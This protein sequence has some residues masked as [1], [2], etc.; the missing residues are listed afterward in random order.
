MLVMTFGDWINEALEKLKAAQVDSPRSDVFAMVEKVTGHEKAWT[1]AHSDELLSKNFIEELNSF[2]KRRAH[3]EPL[4]YILERAW[5]YGRTFRVT[6]DVLIPR[7]ESEDFI[8]ILKDIK[9]RSLVD[10]G[11]GSGCL[12]ISAKLEMPSCQ[13]TATDISEAA[14]KI[15]KQNADNYKVGINFLY[16]S[17]LRPLQ[18]TKYEALVANLPYVPEGLITS[19]EIKTEPSQGLFAGKD[20]LE[21]YRAFWNEIKNLEQ[22]PK[23][24]LT[25]AL[26]DQHSQLKSL[27]KSTGYKLEKTRGLVQLFKL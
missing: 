12:A 14:L 3:R 17:L 21:V 18:D 8:D 27:A 23:F 4:A 19:P 9:P 5:F 1:I 15:A 20:G 16:G 26:P 24:I 2:V 6:S 22:K 7:P 11:T 10:V 25:E 13:I